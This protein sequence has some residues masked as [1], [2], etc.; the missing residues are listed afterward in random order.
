[1]QRKIEGAYALMTLT[2]SHT[3]PGQPHSTVTVT[4]D[5]VTLPEVLSQFEDF[6][7]GCG[8]HFEGSLELVE[9]ESEHEP[10]RPYGNPE[11]DETDD[12]LLSFDG[13]EDEDLE[14]Q[15]ESD[16]KVSDVV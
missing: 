2:C 7:R 14:I 15:H 11:E 13:D 6:L 8:F 10:V 12:S 9:E 3:Y 4:T 16:D 1:M 5:A